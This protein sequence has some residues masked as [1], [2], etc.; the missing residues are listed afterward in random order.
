ML[1][2][3]AGLAV[4]TWQARVAAQQRD[5]ARIQQA[6]AEHINAFMQ[7]M[8]ASADPA[9]KGREV[10][11]AEV[12]DDAIQKMESELADQPEV[13]TEVRRTIGNT[14]RSLG[15]YDKAEPQ[16]RAALE[17]SKQLYGEQHPSTVK[18]MSDLA[19]L[20]RFKGSL[21]EAESLYRRALELQRAQTPEGSRDLAETSVLFAEMLFQKGD[22]K[23][24]EPFAQQALDMSVKF[25]GEQ[26]EI[27]ARALNSLGLVRD[28]EG[29]LSGA[30]EK[31]RQAVDVYRKLPGRPR[32]ELAATLMNLGTNLT[33]QGKYVREKLR[34][35]KVS[36]CFEKYWATLIRSLERA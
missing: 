29:D 21:A 9:R 7:D 10:K 20:L 2:L 31:Y 17:K 27:E 26:N 16:L 11:V 8:L 22:T 3:A 12:L 1:A 33:T 34:C 24:S 4:A 36:V 15:L 14:Y 35:L 6:K 13:L 28:Y 30:Q 5:R 23:A 18:S 19:Y 25:L 32:F